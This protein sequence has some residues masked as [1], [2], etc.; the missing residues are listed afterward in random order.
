MNE[1]KSAFDDHK[2]KY[3]D[4]YPKHANVTLTKRNKFLGVF[5]LILKKIKSFFYN[6][7]LAF[8]ELANTIM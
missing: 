8:K 3:E 7:H 2:L 6:I 1:N 5:S 4:P